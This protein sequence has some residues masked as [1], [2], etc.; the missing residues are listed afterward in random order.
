MDNVQKDNT[1]TWTAKALLG[2]DTV[3]TLKRKQQ[4]KY[5]CLLFV[6]AQFTG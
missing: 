4:L 3:N 1:V 6:S 2:N 5:G